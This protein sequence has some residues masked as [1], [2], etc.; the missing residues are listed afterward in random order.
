[1]DLTSGYTIV[2]QL[3]ILQSAFRIKSILHFSVPKT[4]TSVKHRVCVN[5]GEASSPGKHPF[6][7]KQCSGENESKKLLV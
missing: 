2:Y 3:E 4:N 1:M 5:I 6:L 7:Q